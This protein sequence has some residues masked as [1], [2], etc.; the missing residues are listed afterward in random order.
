MLLLGV[1]TAFLV[2]V[3]PGPLG[4]RSGAAAVEAV[5]LSGTRL[6]ALTGEGRALWS[7]DFG[8]PVVARKDPPRGAFA[9]TFAWGD[10]DGDA[11]SE[12]LVSV[13]FGDTATNGPRPHDELFAFS[14]EGRVLW[15]RRLDDELTFGAGR[16]G[17][18]WFDPGPASDMGR[19][20][21][22]FEVDGRKRVAWAQCHHTWWPSILTVLDAKGQLVSRWVHAG[23]IYTV[24]PAQVGGEPRLLV[25][26]V[27]NSR[28]A[29]FLAV[30]DARRVSGA[31]PEPQGSPYECLA[32]EPGRPLR[33]FSF[34]P[35]E[36][37]LAIAPYNHVF[38][39]RADA[40]GVEVRTMEA[41]TLETSLHMQGISRFSSALALEHASWSS[42]WD[43]RHRELEQEGRIHHSAE[44]CPNRLGRPRVREWTPDS[45]WRELTPA[46]APVVSV[47]RRR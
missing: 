40:G 18:P 21:S 9:Q 16:F 22:L 6:T 24:V 29:G 34:P 38:D 42:G 36:L 32:C 2:L 20:V 3:R 5:A 11:R 31:G 27:S 14:S 25:G 41:S 26:G 17:P 46:D 10:L 44:Q 4:A 12:L 35:S 19:S 30:L 7:H 39:V 23:V 43:S 28:E 1:A 37:L 13:L 47:S 8:R 15:S 33:Y 45:G